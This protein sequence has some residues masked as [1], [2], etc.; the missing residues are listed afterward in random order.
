MYVGLHAKW[1]VF[2]PILTKSRIPQQMPM[3]VPK[4]KFRLSPSSGTR[5]QTEGNRRFSSLCERTYV[6]VPKVD[7]SLPSFYYPTNAHNVKTAELLNHIKIMEAAPTC[8]GLQRNHHQGATA[9][10]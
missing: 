9:S 8:F 7:V 1:P 6:F 4:I 3:K 2:I 10:A 5:G